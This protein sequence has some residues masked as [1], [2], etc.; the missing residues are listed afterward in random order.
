MSG[1]EAV[2]TGGLRIL[3]TGPPGS[4][5]T[6]VLR[7]LI[8]LLGAEG[9]K[10]GG[11]VTEEFREGG[12][13]AGF[14]VRE[15]DGPSAVLA[16]AGQP[17]S[18]RVGRYGVDIEAF[19]SIALSAIDHAVEDAHVVV[20][21]EIGRME[22]ASARFIA[23][24]DAVFALP[25]PVVATVHLAAHPVTDM[26]TRAP[27]TDVVHVSDGNRDHLPDQ[28][29]ERLLILLGRGLASR[30]VRVPP[31]CPDPAPEPAWSP[32]SVASFPPSGRWRF[33]PA[34]A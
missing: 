10:L 7:R 28:L 19:E 24:L 12:H 22:L 17:G 5:K 8:A 14:T 34:P 23:R 20:I 2:R 26:L 18:A 1:E 21:D 33:P 11:F 30:P 25:R 31:G 3:L 32:G 13:R 9:V 15:I 6:T 27:G 4:G 29:S 16:R